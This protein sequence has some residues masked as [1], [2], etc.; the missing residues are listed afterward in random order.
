VYVQPLS[1]LGERNK[2]P[3]PL[4]AAGAAVVA[5]YIA[6]YG[7]RAAAK[8]Y[9][10]KAISEGKKH[11]K[12]MVTKPNA[13]QT[14]VKAATKGQRAYR[15]GTRAAAGVGAVGGGIAGVAAMRKKLNAET[16]AKKRAQM[17]VAIEKTVAKVELE[18]QKSKPTAQAPKKSPR[19]KM[20]TDPVRP[21]ARPVK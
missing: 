6:Q 21:K 11:A 17:Q 4:I 14:Q 8:K 13:G 7:L 16:D 10:K 9:T 3:L 2:M 12:D 19:P 5:R 1:F 15:A 20:R 18:K